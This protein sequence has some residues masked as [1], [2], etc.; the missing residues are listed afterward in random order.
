MIRIN[1]VRTARPAAKR[2]RVLVSRREAI[3]GGVL[4]V[5][6]FGMLLYLASR[7]KAGS[8]EQEVRSA[9]AP[10][11][12]Q[13]A[14][15]PV[16]T[17]PAAAAPAP[18]VPPPVASKVLPPEPPAPA[19]KAAPGGSGC[20]ISDFVI[21]QGPGT[22]T[23]TLRSNTEPAYKSQELNS[24]DRIALDIADCRSAIPPKQAIQTVENPVLKRV[25]AGQW[26]TDP[27]ICRLVLDLARMPRYQV[28]SV[29]QGVEIRVQE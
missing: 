10:E 14:A 17:P 12:A 16:T 26:K 21:Q 3:I 25:R 15:P 4:L 7:P 5:A 22:V 23:V 1:L 29:P 24:P 18:P 20:I 28:R 11:P 19:P 27:P 2:E 6:A 8:Q 13:P 9:P